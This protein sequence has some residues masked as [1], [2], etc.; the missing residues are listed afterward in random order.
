MK[1]TVEQL[2]N[3]IREEVE[4]V[5]PI[6]LAESDDDDKSEATGHA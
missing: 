2:R 4:R 1:I 3:I 6:D 5:V